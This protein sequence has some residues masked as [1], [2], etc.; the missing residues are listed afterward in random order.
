[1][2]TTTFSGDID[3]RKSELL[4]ANV[5]DAELFHPGAHL[6]FELLVWFL[7]PHGHCS[8]SDPTIQED[9]KD[10]AINDQLQLPLEVVIIEPWNRHAHALTAV[11]HVAAKLRTAFVEN[12]HAGQCVALD[13]RREY[14][15]H[16][17]IGAE[18]QVLGTVLS[19]KV[20]PK[21]DIHVNDKST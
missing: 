2:Y 4:H 16:G 17:R 14:E 18:T 8:R 12:H 5:D 20:S 7:R 13:R 15:A 3:S 11:R 9:L 6:H 10:G 21:P 1:M 19:L